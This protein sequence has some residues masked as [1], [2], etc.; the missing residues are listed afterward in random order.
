LRGKGPYQEGLVLGSKKMTEIKKTRR[1][2]LIEGGQ[3]ENQPN[4]VR[5][6]HKK[7]LLGRET[8]MGGGLGHS[9]KMAI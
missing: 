4:A 5:E 6:G 8:R 9:A 1:T 3:G 2:P 7:K